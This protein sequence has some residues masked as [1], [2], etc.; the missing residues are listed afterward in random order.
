METNLFSRSEKKK[1]RTRLSML[2]L[3]HCFPHHRS[4]SAAPLV[5]LFSNFNEAFHFLPIHT[6]LLCHP[7]DEPCAHFPF[8]F[9]VVQRDVLHRL[10]QDIRSKPSTGPRFFPRG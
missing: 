8:S 7:G 10:S 2:F 6:S 3:T 9:G 4:Q 1:L 5:I